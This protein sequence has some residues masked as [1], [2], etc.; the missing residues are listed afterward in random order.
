[1][2]VMQ[3]GKEMV[4]EMTFQSKVKLLCQKMKFCR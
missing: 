3:Q 4:E 2:S 1:M